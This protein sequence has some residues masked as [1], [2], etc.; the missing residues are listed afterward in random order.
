[1]RVRHLDGSRRLNSADL[2]RTFPV[3]ETRPEVFCDQLC[4]SLKDWIRT[5]RDRGTITW[6]NARLQRLSL[7]HTGDI[8]RTGKLAQAFHQRRAPQPFHRS[9]RILP[10]PPEGADPGA[11]GLTAG[12]EGRFGLVDQAPV[13]CDGMLAM[14]N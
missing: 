3:G 8:E 14:L 13:P 4:V 7:S 5:L 11:Q 12:T 6:I 9:Y 2:I 10:S 1:M